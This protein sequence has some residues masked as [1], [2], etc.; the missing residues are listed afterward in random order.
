MVLMRQ[1][2]FQVKSAR[3]GTSTI[4]QA[5]LLLSGCEPMLMIDYY[6]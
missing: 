6:Q 3:R 4:V 2:L 1:E 5:S